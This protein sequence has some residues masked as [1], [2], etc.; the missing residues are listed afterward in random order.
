IGE[1][2]DGNGRGRLAKPSTNK[3]HRRLQRVGIRCRSCLVAGK[4][5]EIQGWLRQGDIFRHDQCRGSCT[6]SHFIAR[7]KCR[8]IPPKLGR[9]SPVSTAQNGR[10]SFFTCAR[11]ANKGLEFAPS[12]PR[13][14]PIGNLK[15][16][17]PLREVRRLRR[18]RIPGHISRAS[19]RR[20]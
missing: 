11:K 16:T 5:E 3:L 19:H 7:G 6:K 12:L 20:E 13:L 9:A 17:V 18:N 10:S 2:G 4:T 14:P 15:Q 8:P 1:I